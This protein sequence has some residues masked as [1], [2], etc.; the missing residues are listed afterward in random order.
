MARVA[1]FLN[2]CSHD[3]D[4]LRF[5]ADGTAAE[6]AFLGTEDNHAIDPAHGDLMDPPMERNDVDLMQEDLLNET[7]GKAADVSICPLIFLQVIWSFMTS[8]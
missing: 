5:V 1:F 4:S 8:H 7:Y 6:D 3:S 2:V